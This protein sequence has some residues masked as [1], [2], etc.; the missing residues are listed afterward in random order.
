[1]QR[2]SQWVLAL[3][4]IRAAA[5]FDETATSP[6]NNDDDDTETR[7]TLTQT[8]IDAYQILSEKIATE[9]EKLPFEDSASIFLYGSLQDYPK[10]ESEA[11]DRWKSAMHGLIAYNATLVSSSSNSNEHQEELLDYLQ[12]VVSQLRSIWEKDAP[13]LSPLQAF[14]LLKL[15]Q[16]AVVPLANVQDAYVPAAAGY[17]EAL[18]M[19][20]YCRQLQVDSCFHVAVATATDFYRRIKDSEGVQRVA[21]LARV[22]TTKEEAQV[23]SDG[24]VE[25]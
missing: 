16:K 21:E 5:R 18:A 22:R 13:Q 12:V 11:I 20:E 10:D 1:M 15:M 4:Y 19:S 25:M 17:A 8:C 2:R 24:K 14:L 7:S 23:Q 6:P 3:A 9:Q